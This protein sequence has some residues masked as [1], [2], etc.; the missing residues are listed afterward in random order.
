MHFPRKLSFWNTLHS[1]VCFFSFFV[2]WKI[3]IWVRFPES[4][5]ECNVL[6]L[7]YFSFFGES[8]YLFDTNNFAVSFVA[9]DVVYTYT[10]NKNSTNSADNACMIKKR[11][12]SENIDRCTFRKVAQSNNYFFSQLLQYR[13]TRYLTKYRKGR[14]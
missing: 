14:C 11:H 6:Y 4:K 10:P 12:S 2:T 13:S 3:T 7:D 1:F 9:D 8:A 5:R